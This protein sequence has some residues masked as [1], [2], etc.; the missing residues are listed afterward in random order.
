LIGADGII[1]ARWD[2]LFTKE[3]LRSELEELG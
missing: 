2:N 1:V 3:E